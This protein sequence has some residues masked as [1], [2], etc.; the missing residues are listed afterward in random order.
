MPTEVAAALLWMAAGAVEVVAAT[1]ALLGLPVVEATM[2][3]EGLAATGAEGPVA[4]AA[5]AAGS[6]C[7]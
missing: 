4:A 2:G 1:G 3:D 6:E 7:S 5:G